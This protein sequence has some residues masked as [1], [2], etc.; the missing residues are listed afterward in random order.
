LVV[1]FEELLSAFW[2]VKPSLLDA[3][4]PDLV[5]VQAVALLLVYLLLCA[6]LRLVLDSLCRPGIEEVPAHFYKRQVTSL[7]WLGVKVL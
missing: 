6:F 7:F 5:P 4:L 2:V 3:Y 1:V